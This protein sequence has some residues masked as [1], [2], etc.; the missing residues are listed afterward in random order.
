[1]LTKV[2]LSTRCAVWIAMAIS[3]VL[4][5]R[6]FKSFAPFQNEANAIQVNTEI[7]LWVVVALALAIAVDR[8]LDGIASWSRWHHDD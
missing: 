3:V 2:L 1:M 4:L 7:T 8:V 6:W 5:I